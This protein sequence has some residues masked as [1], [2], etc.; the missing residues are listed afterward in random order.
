MNDGQN[1]HRQPTTAA[2]LSLA[3]KLNQYPMSFA[4]YLLKPT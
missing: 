3:P 4:L 1:R 2:L